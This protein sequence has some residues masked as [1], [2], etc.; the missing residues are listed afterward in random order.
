MGI[1]EFRKNAKD[2]VDWIC[3]Y[4]ASNEKLPVRSEVEPG[5]LRPLLPKAAPQSP[6]NFSAIMQDFQAKIMPGITHWQSPNFFAY[7]PSN[8]SFP[9]MLGEMLS[10]A[11]STVGFCW[12]GSPATTEL[13]T[14]V[15]DWLGKLL[16]LPTSFLAFDEQGK[17]GLGGGV[18]QGSA[19]ES[20]LVAL[21]AARARALA[22]RPMEDAGNLVAY[23][24]DQSHSSIKKACM[25]AGTPYVRIIP[26]SPEDDYAFDA[27]ALEEAI[28][29]DIDAGL[30]PFYCVATIGTTSSCA[31][32]PIAEIGRITQQYGL[33]LHVDAAYAGVSSMLPEYRHYFVGLEL[34]DSFITNGHKWLLTNF[35]CSC[36]WVRNAE[37][38]K[39][40]LSLTPA[41]LRGKGNDLDYKDWQVPLGRRFRSLKLWFVMRSYG[42][43]NIKKFLRHHIQLGQLFVSL[44]QTDARLEIVTP[45]RWG[46]ICFRVRGAGNEATQELLERVNKSGRAFLVHT[47]LSGRFVARMA[48]GGSLTQERHVRGAWQ[49]IS[50]CTTEVL[51]ARSKYSKGA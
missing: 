22:G 9:A 33:W 42:T 23:S 47:E 38:L 40:A 35:D 17:R 10:S 6:E 50:E 44:I 12:I 27:A 24:S 21:L 16:C 18:I 20:T 13:E 29:E 45:P 15:M 2:M 19:S 39:A 49:L 7:F 1:E 51:A 5:Y 31:V 32:D 43:E 34:V 14:I 11:L 26:A 48:I 25:V 30:L 36:M 37:P 8:S 41:Y 3:D 28:R 46:L 4:Y